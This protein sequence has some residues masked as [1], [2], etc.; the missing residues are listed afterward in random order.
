MFLLITETYMCNFQVF[1]FWYLI[2]IATQSDI[3][4]Q[5]LDDLNWMQIL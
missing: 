4:K 5:L 2:T 1:Y 3:L